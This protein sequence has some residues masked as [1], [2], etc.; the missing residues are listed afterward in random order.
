MKTLLSVFK[1]TS[2]QLLGKATSSLSTII[3]LGLITRNF[4]AAETG[5]LTL[6]LTYLGFFALITDFGVNAHVLPEFLKGDSTKRWQKLLGMRILISLIATFFAGVLVSFWPGQ[7]LQFK[8]TVLLGLF[9]VIEPAI[10]I[11]AVAVF[12][13]RLR[14]DL[15]VLANIGG[16]AVLL[17]TVVLLVLQK[18]GVPFII[19][20]YSVGWFI[21]AV[22]TLLLVKKFV[23][24]LLPVFDLSYM[25]Q[26]LLESWPIS[27]TVVLNLVYFRVDTFMIS[28]FRNFSEVGVYNVAY[29]IFQTLLVVPAFIMNSYYPHM[30]KNLHEDHEKFIKQVKTTTLS[31][32][33]LATAGTFLTLLLAPFVIDL[34]TGGKGFSGAI[35]SLRILSV[36]FPAFFATSILMW[37]MIALKKYKT[38]LIIYLLGLAF[39]GALNFFFIP[40]YTYIASSW[41]T[42]ASEYLVLIMQLIVLQAA[43]KE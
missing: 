38:M 28:I 20:G 24:S 30:L 33:G 42:V 18:I 12:Q 34:L 13:S 8:Q 19:L 9:G 26:V 2:W 22:L 41:I 5:V 3:I 43:L 11:T 39:N 7:S 14:Y 36:S 10:Y 29:Q 6:A 40:T 21:S 17:L 32:I 16:I 31:M 1:Q 35:T 25:K 23:T 4:G 15:V 37:T 27:L